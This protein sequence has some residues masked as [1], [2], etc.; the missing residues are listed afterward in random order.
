MRVRVLRLRKKTSHCVWGKKEEPKTPA[1][2]TDGK[3]RHRAFGEATEIR[4]GNDE[5]D[6]GR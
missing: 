6:K 5:N 1:R 2:T 4:G 3:G